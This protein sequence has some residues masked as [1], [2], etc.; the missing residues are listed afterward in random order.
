LFETGRSL[1]DRWRRLRT[2]NATILQTGYGI[3]LGE[4]WWYRDGR[5]GRK[6]WWRSGGHP[7]IE[8][9]SR[10]STEPWRQVQRS[11]TIV[12]DVRLSLVHQTEKEL[13]VTVG[14][15]VIRSMIGSRHAE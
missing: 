2:V 6:S 7:T 13:I 15:H 8:L 5:L 1:E 11:G 4:P 9:R 12:A 10:R 3:R 14:A